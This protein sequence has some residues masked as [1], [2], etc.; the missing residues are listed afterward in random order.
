ML[1]MRESI[2]DLVG[3]FIYLHILKV[4]EKRLVLDQ[5]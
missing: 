1:S 4:T 5:F 2:N 3:S